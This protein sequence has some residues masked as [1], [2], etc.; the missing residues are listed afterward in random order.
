[1]SH[2]HSSHD[3]SCCA[4]RDEAAAA[5]ADD[6]R[7]NLLPPDYQGTVYT[8]PMDPEV[9]QP[10][11]GTCPIC[12][13]ALEAE[14][15][16]PAEEDT[17]ELDDMS[18]RFWVSLV[19]TLPLFTFAMA[20]MIPGLGLKTWLGEWLGYGMAQW[21]QLALAA[22]VV[23]WAGL[24]FLARG[25][26]SLRTLN[27]N[28]FTLIMLGVLAA[29]FYSLLAT[30][31][32]QL[33][34]AS[35]RSMFGRVGVYYEAAA[36]IVTL[37]LLGQV[38]ELRARS[39]TSGAIRALMDLAPARARRV[40]ADVTGPLSSTLAARIVVAAEH[41]DG[42]R[43]FVT[44]DRTVVAPSLTW[45]PSD[46]VRI[47][48]VG[49]VTRF[50]APFDRGIPAIAGDANA[51]PRHRFYGEPGDGLTRFRNTRHQVTGLIGLGGGWSVNAGA[52]Y[53]TGT[54]AGFS[55]DHTILVQLDERVLRR[56]RRQRDYAVDDLSARAELAG[57]IGAHRVAIGLKGYHL[58]YR[59]KYL[60]VSPTAAAPYAI[61]V[62]NPVYGQPKPTPR[63]F[64]DNRERRWAGTLYVQDMWSLGDRLTLLGGLRLDPYRQRLHNRLT[65]VTG[66]NKDAPVN[67]RFGG[68][69]QL[70]EQVAL[71]ANWG[72]SFL[73]NSGTDRRGNGFDPERGRGYEAGV[74]VR[75]ARL[76]LGATW[77]DITKNGILTNDPT[78]PGFLAPVGTLTSRGVELDASLRLGE[79]WQI[80]GNYAWTHARTDD[81]TFATDRA[82]NVPAHSGTLFAVGRFLDADAR[83]ASVSAGIGYVGRRAGAIDASGLVLPA[84]V[85]LKA[86]ADYTLSATVSVRI[87]ADNLLD[88]RY[89]QSSY[90]PVWVYPGAPR[91]I[92]AV[93]RTRW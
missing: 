4:G 81:A 35:M 58:A 27:F 6:G 8:C 20:E 53:R 40:E 82:L 13:M 33:F 44:L 42:W 93:L 1:M 84:Y 5:A 50:D 17:S 32:P 14:G 46:R 52:A 31:A 12:G 88:E 59:D 30:A 78:D 75:T 62:E 74:T 90:S 51:V 92:R 87:E 77:F 65:G 28:M 67:G 63:P 25:V 11:P 22:P 26:Q 79:R 2:S 64:V 29:F 43:D 19:F 89:A 3:H 21:L 16:P 60:R 49:E 10:T 70:S 54:L 18:R 69:F 36:V 85:K 91:S 47:T 39:A 38:L 72:E 73:L 37:V 24:P 34:P 48:Y 71:H 45:A 57:E 15:L 66:V 86:A 61:E 80:V 56:Q 55:S 9:R 23:F 83:G 41:S 7:Y 76:D 68:R